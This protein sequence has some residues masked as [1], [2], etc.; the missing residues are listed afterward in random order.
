MFKR[1]FIMV[2]A[3]AV[4]AAGTL[5][6]LI[7]GEIQIP[8][9][10]PAALIV[11]KGTSV[12][13]IAEDL[14]RQG[15]IRS[16]PLF[17]LLARWGGVDRRI[18]P[19]RYE[20][21]R[22]VSMYR[23]LR[24]LYDQE[25]MTVKLIFPEGWR[26][27]KFARLLEERAGV[28]ADRF[29]ELCRDSALLAKWGIPTASAEGYLNPA[30]Y[31]FYWGVEPEEVI[32]QL[33]SA[34]QKMFDDSLRARMAELRWNEHQVLTMAS[35]IEAEIMRAEE[36]PRVS[37]VFQNRLKLGMKLQCDPTVLYA[38]G[39]PGRPLK[40]RDLTY[41]SPYNTYLHFGLP[42]GPICNPGKPAVLA[43]LY[44]RNS[45]ELYFVA[46]GDGTHIFTRTLDEHNRARQYVKRLRGGS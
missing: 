14:S 3:V 12:P 42:P 37:G 27:K 46:R 18:L 33:I 36:R 40:Y 22:R 10:I 8:G 38:L 16:Q 9:P 20:F 25:R 11:K 15:L 31:E 29:I 34:T 5:A 23:I 43:A 21:A 6:F 30:A 26:V 45:A 4:I 1:F 13:Q 24:D 19:G 2:F 44:P 41:D 32:E 35:L 39:Y 17:R 28:P 7:F